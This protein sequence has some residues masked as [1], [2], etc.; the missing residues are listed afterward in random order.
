MLAVCVSSDAACQR[1]VGPLQS[2]ACD[3][4]QLSGLSP[5]RSAS[6]VQ[7]KKPESVRSDAG[8]YL[9]IRIQQ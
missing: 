3:Q 9:P 7:K 1:H 8:V 4:E 6:Q 5:A 2:S